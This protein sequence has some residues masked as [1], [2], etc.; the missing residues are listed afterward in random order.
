VRSAAQGNLI[1]VSAAM[2]AEASP[3]APNGG[4]ARQIGSQVRR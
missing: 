1:G 4:D 2:I 3:A